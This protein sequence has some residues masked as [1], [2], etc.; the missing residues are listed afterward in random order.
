[1]GSPF[2]VSDDVQ[3]ALRE[4]EH[5]NDSEGTNLERRYTDKV[6]RYQMR[7]RI[8]RQMAGSIDGIHLNHFEVGEVY[9][10]GVSLAHYLMVCGFALPVIDESPAR[11]VP[12][13]RDV[14]ETPRSMTVIERTEAAEHSRYVRGSVSSPAPR[15]RAKRKT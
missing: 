13:N 14:N 6:P 8:T 11:I 10:I 12:M 1:M 15:P 4:I 7:V 2:T 9:D 5:L 3:G